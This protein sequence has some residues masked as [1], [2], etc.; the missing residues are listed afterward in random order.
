[1]VQ[2]LKKKLGEVDNMQT[3]LSSGKKEMKENQEDW[4]ET[5]S[6]LGMDEETIEA[7]QNVGLED[8]DDDEDEGEELDDEL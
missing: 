8:A 2:E 7:Y 1:M 6:S 4:D 5:V 3:E